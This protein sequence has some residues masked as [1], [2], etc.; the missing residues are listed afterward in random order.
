MLAMYRRAEKEIKIF[1]LAFMCICLC[2]FSAVLCYSAEASNHIVINEIC[3]N[4]FS[5]ICD[6]NGNYS[7][8]VELYNPAK[9]PVSLS[10]FSL[11]DNKNELDKCS[12]ESMI[13]PAKGYMIIWLDGADNDMVGHAS[14]KISQYGESIYLANKAGEIIDF[15]EIPELTYNTVFARSEDGDE[16]WERQAPTAGC[17]N[18]SAQEILTIAL[19]EPEFSAES[20]FYQNKFTLEMKAKKGEV[21]YYTLDGSDPTIHS[22]QYENP[23]VIDDASLQENVYSARSD[24]TAK[25][26]YIPEFYVDKA[27]VVRAIAYSP[28]D[29][30]ISKATTA[31]YFVGFD[32]KHEYDGYAILSLVTDPDNL[33]DDQIG[34]YGNGKALKDYIAEAGTV[35]G[36]IPEGY[37]D[38]EGNQHYMYMSTNAYNVGREW[39]REAYVT[40][41]DNDHDRQMEQSVGIRISGESTR[42]A[43]Q[44]SFNLFARS[45]YGNDLLQYNFFD[46]REYSSVKLR[47]GGSNHQGSKIYDAF[48]QFLVK[49]RAV[50][51]QE[52]RN[53]V[54][55]LN[56]E[57]WGLYNIR[58]RYKEE[59]FKNH[60]GIDKNNIYMID[61]GS[62][63]IGDW[64]AWN[65]YDEMV[66]YISDNDMT[67]PDNYERACQLIDIQSLIDFYCIQLYINN[68][69]VAFDKN[70]GLWR[71][72]QPGEGKYE[73]TKWRFM[74]YDVDASLGDPACN[75]FTESEWWKTDFDLMDEGVI[76]SL[77]ENEEFKQ[78]FISSFLELADTDFRYENVHK[79]L[80]EWKTE[81]ETQV[82]KS[83]QRFI[84]DDIGTEEYDSY[85]SEID[86]F[87][88][89]R[90]GYIIKYLEEEIKTN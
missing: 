44:K 20:G 67:I 42:N 8:Y 88:K 57:Y 71:S 28:Q 41:F 90:R 5:V 6:D 75:T 56:G 86:N 13:I 25:M 23:I 77:L 27:T 49:D 36:E 53:C 81:Y 10:G 4:N 30:T 69:D 38:K 63:S 18:D 31:I 82:V 2:A 19:K 87:F 48:L 15:V 43:A 7:D 22:L 79:S 72:I 59:Y 16:K 34:I 83:H 89:D 3:S 85:I 46:D 62:A 55:F 9:V 39:E 47:N 61:S 21:I 52:S 58:E 66:R 84:S 33:F 51:I 14:F 24:L 35:N 17:S 64:N 1:L 12:L 11:S 29:N 54:V 74:I 70:I 73:D 68:T 37:T 76:K 65:A 60:Y 80:M 26:E 45:I 50:S 40:Y 32:K 78:L